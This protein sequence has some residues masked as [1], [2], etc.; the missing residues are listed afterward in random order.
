MNK[1]LFVFSVDAMVTEDVDALRSMP[2]FQK[3]L[4]GGSEYKGGMRTIYPS[5]TYPAHVSI[6]TG[7]YA[8]KH[9]I[10]SNFDFTTTNKDD[11]WLWFSDRIQV[12][13]IF[14]VAKKAGLK[15]ASVS[16]PVTGCNPNVDYLID[17][18]WMPLPGD[19]LASSFRRAGS[20]DEVIRIMESHTDL[21]GEGWELGGKKHFMQWPQVDRWI[22][23]CTCDI[24]RQFRPEVTFMHTGAFDITRHHHGVFS[25]YLDDCRA[26]LD[27]YIGQVG[28]TLAELGLLEDTNF[29][30]V[31]DHGQRD[32]NRAINLNVK[33]ADAGLIHTDENGTVTDW[34]AYCFSNAMS[35]YTAQNIGAGRYDRVKQGLKAS[36]FMVVVF[37]LLITV[38]IFLFGDQLLSLFLDPGDTSGALGCGLT[39]MHT[40]SLFYIL[41]GLLFVS[42]GMLRGSG[43]MGA[44]TLS[45][46]AN[47]FSRVAVAYAL[48]YLTPLGANAI[49]WSIPA[50][51]AIGSVVS[52]LRVKSGKWMRQAVSE[53]I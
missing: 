37:S 41:M 49:W 16:W 31:S 29:I 9:G 2:N 15:T 35:S 4:A 42:N 44:F 27:R 10:T 26:D 32:I 24:L 5:V 19:T 36:L 18:Y 45:S 8:G 48:A 43:D 13:D 14:A 22:V 3:Y 47:L 21:L 38:I 23:A 40:V 28:D 20:S 52:L 7:C 51:W 6:L 25:S 50:G 39:Y 33:L 46:M 34:Q 30:M 11:S 1:R 53:R 12:E 17:E